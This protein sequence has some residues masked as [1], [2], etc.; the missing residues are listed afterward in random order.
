[1]KEKS[2]IVDRTYEF[3]LEIIKLVNLLPKNTSGSVIS[4][5]IMKAGTS[6]G[7][8]FIIRN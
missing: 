4:N 7:A 2:N 3:A 8:K 6:I 1:M 5:Q